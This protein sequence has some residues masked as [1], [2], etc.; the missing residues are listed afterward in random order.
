MV[1][2]AIHGITRMLNQIRAGRSLDLS[3]SNTDLRRPSVTHGPRGSLLAFSLSPVTDD[4]YRALSAARRYT[5]PVR[6][7]S[8]N[9]PLNLVIATLERV[10]DEVQVTGRIVSPTSLQ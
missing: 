5:I 4:T 10:G 2:T 7:V 1:T 8:L 3:W 6:L 9:R